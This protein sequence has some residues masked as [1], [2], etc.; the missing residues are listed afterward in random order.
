MFQIENFRLT[1]WIYTLFYIFIPLIMTITAVIIYRRNK[2]VQ[3][4]LQLIGGG[5]LLIVNTVSRF[6]FHWQLNLV[7]P[8]GI[9][10]IS[11]FKEYESYGVFVF[12][13]LFSAGF[14]PYLY[15]YIINIDRNMVIILLQIIPIVL[16]ITLRII[17]I[18]MTINVPASQ[19][20]EFSTILMKYYIHEIIRL[21]FVA[22]YLLMG[23]K[24]SSR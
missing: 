24:I 17:S 15:R 8:A 18:W 1:M 11:S 12:I 6:Y 4:L 10:E 7:I 14:I 21:F 9:E 3:P 19:F 2:S 23:I 22:G 16:I 5:G 13:V 20:L